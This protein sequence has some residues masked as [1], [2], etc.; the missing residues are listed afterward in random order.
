MEKIELISFQIIS[1]VG[2]ARS[3]YIEAIQLAKEGKFEEARNKIIAG[4]DI[5]AD[6]HRAHASLIQQ[7]ASGE[8]VEFQLLLMH[9]EDQLISAEG[10]K[11]IASEFIDV[12]EKMAS[13]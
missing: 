6:G 10:F 12:Y 8:R 3:M 13:I 4:D 7:E 1:T 11:I 2:T 5:F 9:A